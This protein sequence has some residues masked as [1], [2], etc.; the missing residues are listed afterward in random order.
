MRRLLGGIA[1]TIVTIFITGLTAWAV[2]LFINYQGK[3]TDAGGN[4][5]DGDFQMRFSLY[6]AP[7]GGTVLWSED[8]YGI[9]IHKSY[10]ITF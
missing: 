2:P 1:L 9:Y 6:D 4:P 3:L 10:V 5:L 7:T 8:L